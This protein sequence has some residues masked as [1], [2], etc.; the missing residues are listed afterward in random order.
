MISTAALFLVLAADWSAPQEAY[1]DE[2]LAATY[3]ARFDGEALLVEAKLEPKWHTFAMDNRRRHLEKLAGRE[4]LGVEKPTVIEVTGLTLTGPWHQPPPKDFSKPDLQIFTFGFDKEARFAVKAKLAPGA[5]SAT[6]KLKAQACSASV[7]LNVEV[8]L[9]VP[10][11]A[12][13]ANQPEANAF[14]GL[15]AVKL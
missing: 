13:P 11:P 7:C 2:T 10:L 14:I 1:H 9:D 3:R 4:S 6:V 12:G 5:K 8:T 15:E